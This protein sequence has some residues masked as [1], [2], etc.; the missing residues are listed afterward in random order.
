MPQFQ[1]AFCSPADLASAGFNSFRTSENVVLGHKEQRVVRVFTP[2][3]EHFWR[4]KNHEPHIYDLVKAHVH[5]DKCLIDIGSWIGSATLYAAAGGA[6]VVTVEPNPNA[7]TI[8]HHNIELNGFFI[9]YGGALPS[10][11]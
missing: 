9:F 6:R 2:S 4:E 11:L 5:T 8:L 10:I 1:D 3:F 7:C